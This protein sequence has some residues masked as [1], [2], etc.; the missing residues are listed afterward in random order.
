M[1]RRQREMKELDECTLQPKTNPCIQDNNQEVVIVKG[2]GRHLE[3]Q[4]LKKKQ[5]EEKRLREAEVFGINHKFAVNA[6]DYDIN[7]P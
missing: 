6:A 5:T 3:L 1:E 7:N 2:L 4:E